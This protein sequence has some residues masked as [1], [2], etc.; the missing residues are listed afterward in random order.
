MSEAMA[1]TSSIS[2]ESKSNMGHDRKGL[3]WVEKY[4]PSEL[5][6]ILAHEEIIS[7]IRTL[8]KENKLPHLLFYGP[9]GTGKTTTVL[10]YVVHPLSLFAIYFVPLWIPARSSGFNV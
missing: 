3:P 6:E 8:I 9:P 10:A 2:L 1:S 7:T 4:R 5:D